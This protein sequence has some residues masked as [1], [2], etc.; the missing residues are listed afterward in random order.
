LASALLPEPWTFLLCRLRDPGRLCEPLPEQSQAEETGHISDHFDQRRG[1]VVTKEGGAQLTYNMILVQDR[2]EIPY[3][4]DNRR[5]NPILIE[6]VHAARQLS[7]GKQNQQDV[8]HIEEL[9]QAQALFGGKEDPGLTHQY[10]KEN[11]PLA[12]R[13]SKRAQMN[14]LSGDAVGSGIDGSSQVHPGL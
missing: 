13:E 5:D 1:S 10:G 6:F 9:A 7:G 14:G 4:I 3:L 8:G 11:F 12:T 2:I